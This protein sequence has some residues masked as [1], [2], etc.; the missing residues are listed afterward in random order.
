MK[1]KW[2]IIYNNKKVYNTKDTKETAKQYD[3]NI[4]LIKNK[5]KYYDKMKLFKYKWKIVHIKILKKI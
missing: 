3:K 4:F 1:K 2:K 5:N